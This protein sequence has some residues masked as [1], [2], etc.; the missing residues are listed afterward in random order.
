MEDKNVVEFLNRLER[1]VSSKETGDETAVA[2]V[3]A[4]EL[5]DLLA[6][7]GTREFTEREHDTLAGIRKTVGVIEFR[8][9]AFGWQRSLQRQKEHR[10]K[11]ERERA[12]K[13]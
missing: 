5:L 8:Q 7:E 13:P 1:I 9:R 6:K 4:S 2:L 11:C 3:F 10:E 12:V